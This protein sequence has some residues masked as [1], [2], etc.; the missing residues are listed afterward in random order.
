MR[1]GRAEHLG[2]LLESVP[3]PL[4]LGFR[5]LFRPFN[6]GNQVEGMFGVVWVGHDRPGRET[7]GAGPTATHLA[8]LRLGF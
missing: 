1:G 4:F 5:H 3:H 2:E 6:V 7:N 8:G